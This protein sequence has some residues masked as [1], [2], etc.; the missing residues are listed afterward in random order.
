MAPTTSLHPWP[1]CPSAPR[2][3]LVAHR[4]YELFD[5]QADDHRIELR[6]SAED[7]LSHR[8]LPDLTPE[9]LIDQF[10]PSLQTPLGPLADE[11]TLATIR[12]TD[13]LPELDFEF[14]LGGG[15]QPSRSGGPARHRRARTCPTRTR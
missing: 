14:P 8:P 10:L 1:I 3:G 5:S 9:D 6:R 2:F 15:G 7:A 12:P 13:R 4:I 11:L